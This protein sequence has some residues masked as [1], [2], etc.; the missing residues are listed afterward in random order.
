MHKRTELL[1]FIWTL[2]VFLTIVSLIVGKIEPLIQ[3]LQWLISVAGV[4]Y[5]LHL[6]DKEVKKIFKRIK[7]YF[8]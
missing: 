7:K 2:I 8:F 6:C 5:V 4:A 1:L 3:I